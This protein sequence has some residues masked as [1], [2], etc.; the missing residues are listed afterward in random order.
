MDSNSLTDSKMTYFSDEIKKV[1]VT[2][3]TLKIDNKK[4]MD[5]CLKKVGKYQT[6]FDNLH[7][8]LKEVDKTFSSQERKLDHCALDVKKV[9]EECQKTD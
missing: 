8:M 1:D 3:E 7:S 5:K 4:T 2:L 6:E 9:T